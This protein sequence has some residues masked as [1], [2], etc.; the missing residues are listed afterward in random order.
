[1]LVRTQ[2]NLLG[3]TAAAVSGSRVSG[4]SVL[5][6][7]AR[8]SRRE[9]AH[10]AM[11]ASPIPYVN[12]QNYFLHLETSF[13]ANISNTALVSHSWEE[14]AGDLVAVTVAVELPGSEWCGI[15]RGSLLGPS[16]GADRSAS[17]QTLKLGGWQS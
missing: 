17:I 3:R 7:N 9:T 2:L 5:N 6:P 8:R 12:L 11:I 1:M 10:Q 13:K 14:S 4:A 15:K 16:T